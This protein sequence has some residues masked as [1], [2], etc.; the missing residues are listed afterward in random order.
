MRRL[1]VIGIGLGAAG[2]LT[3]DAVAAMR[4]VDTF[5]VPDKGPRTADLLSA[6]RALCE[7]VID[8][9]R[10]N[11][12]AVPDPERG[13][14]AERSAG[15]YRD[16]VAAWHRERVARFITEIQQL[17]EDATIGFLVWGDPAFYD[18]TLRMVE[19]IVQ[20]IPLEVRVLPGISAIQALAAAHRIP[21][22]AVG[23]PVHI[24]TGR[25]LVDEWSPD[26]GTVV[27]MLD[28]HLHCRD[29]VDRAPEV[30]LYWGACLGSSAETLRSGRLVDVI[31]DVV[32][33]RARLRDDQGWVMDVYALVP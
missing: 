1:S 32:T 16:A 13:P 6:R 11:L 12:V 31:D 25:R 26:L 23:G 24:T 30:Q 7:Q 22:N 18:S 19:Q 8:H 2:H 3:G 27:V 28:G 29:L 20:T 5:L 15:E 9:D 33:T 10:W 21:L 14:D 4:E 17:P